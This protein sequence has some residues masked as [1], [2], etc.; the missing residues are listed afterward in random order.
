MV[1]ILATDKGIAGGVEELAARREFIQSV[2]VVRVS[3]W[4]Y[5]RIG[6]KL[7]QRFVCC[8]S[9]D[10]INGIHIT[11]HIDDVFRLC[12]LNEIWSS[13]FVIANT[14]IWKKGSDK[15]LLWQMLTLNREIE[16]YF[17]KQELSL[18]RIGVLH[19]SVTLNSFG[20]FGFQ[21][22]VSD[23]ELFRNRKKG[24]V[25]AM[26]KAYIKVSPILLERDVG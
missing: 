14:C 6:D 19:Q 24:F 4:R 10:G 11:A 2:T 26:K 1:W 13:S 20:T 8:V 21:T 23:R 3:E 7:S 15:K 25:E 9:D 22:S 18:D 5:L 16:L 17:A 12:L